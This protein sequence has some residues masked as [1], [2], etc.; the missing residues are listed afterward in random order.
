MA[1]PQHVVIV[2]DGNRR[3]AKKQGR[4]IFFGHQKGAETIGKILQ[5]ALGLKIPCLTIWGCSLANITERSREEV[6]FLYALFE[7]Y[8]K[9]LLKSKEVRKNEV[10]IRVIGRWQEFFPEGLKAATRELMELTKNYNHYRLNFLMAY[11]GVDE[12]TNAIQKIVSLPK[13]P[14]SVTISPILVKQHLW[15]SDLPP[16]DLV[17]RAGGEPHWS[18]GMMMWDVAESKLH[19]TETLWPDFS[20]EEFKRIIDGY[21]KTERRF[22]K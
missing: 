7:Q 14:H 3:W 20:G 10:R 8:F 4:P 2:P 9:K 22:G 18:A 21:G 1:V 15:T 11:S 16:V 17:I 13:N 6:N 12:M 19:F 5:A